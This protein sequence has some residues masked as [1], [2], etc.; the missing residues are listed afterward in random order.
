VRMVDAN[1]VRA[2]IT[3]PLAIEAMRHA[4]RALA[5]GTVVAPNEFVMNTPGDVHVK[6][7]YLQGS[8]WVV[9]KLAAAG[10][11]SGGNSGCFLILSADSGE[12]HTFVNDGGWMTEA[13][14]AAAGALSIDLLARK[15]ASTVAIIG[16]GIQA[17][18][19]LDALRSIRNIG[20]VRIAARSVE[21]VRT[22]A[23]SHNAK[24]CSSIIE[25][26]DGADIVLC[27]TTSREVIVDRVA[28]GTHVTSIGVDMVGKREL[29][30]ALIEAADVVAVDDI[31]LSKTV[32]IL[33]T[34]V[35]TTA[36]TLGDILLK[37][38]YGR[39]ND[40]QITVAGLSGLGVQDAA[41][42]EVLIAQ[43]RDH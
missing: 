22:F 24:P 35:R 30:A 43:L 19:Q 23:S 18:F 14:T 21:R 5:E 39:V 9:F 33:Q 28:P 37:R 20:E 7:A 11:P 4:F 10:F 38:A 2:H 12:I 15:D 34:S 41:I 36:V 17:G 42:A 26:I 6:G 8:K 16:A 27:A 1:T 13:R 3:W 32:G 31:D 25:A 29:S 40:E